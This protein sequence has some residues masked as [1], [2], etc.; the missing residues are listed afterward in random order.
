MAGNIA[1]GTGFT[2]TLEG[3]RRLWICGS[4]A[5]LFFGEEKIVLRLRGR[6]LTVCGDCLSLESYDTKELCVSGRISS[7]SLEA[8]R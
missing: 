1:D 2:L 4:L 3:D 7:V 8:G 5:V 6:I